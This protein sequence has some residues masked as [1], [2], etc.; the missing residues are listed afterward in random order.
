MCDAISDEDIINTLANRT[1]TRV[2]VLQDRQGNEKVYR[3]LAGAKMGQKS[4]SWRN[5]RMFSIDG[6]VR[7]VET[8]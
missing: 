1:K 3:T 6:Y 5:A 4:Y 8:Q 7:E 2:Y